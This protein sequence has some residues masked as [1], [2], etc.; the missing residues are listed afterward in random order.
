MLQID[1]QAIYNIN[2]I[3]QNLT[4]KAKQARAAKR[5]W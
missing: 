4:Q 5:G 1:T 3:G 2:E